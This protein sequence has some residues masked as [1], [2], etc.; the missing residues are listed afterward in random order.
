[1]DR[2]QNRVAKE[3]PVSLRGELYRALAYLCG[4]EWRARL[5]E[6]KSCPPEEIRARSLSR[7]LEHAL[8]EVPYYRDLEASGL[9]LEAFPLLARRTLRAEYTD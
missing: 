2:H 9:G 1:M 7:L 5:R 4:T 3:G 8:T 6:I